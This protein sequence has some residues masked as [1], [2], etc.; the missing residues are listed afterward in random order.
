MFKS[1][2]VS[3]YRYTEEYATNSIVSICAELAKLSVQVVL[4]TKKDYRKLQP[5]LKIVELTES[6]QNIVLFSK[7][8]NMHFQRM[9]QTMLI[10][11]EEEQ[12][13]LTL[14][15]VFFRP[16]YIGTGIENTQNYIDEMYRLQK[17]FVFSN[18]KSVLDI[19]VGRFNSVN[20]ITRMTNL[21]IAEEYVQYLKCLHND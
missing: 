12:N 20:Q 14:K 21:E 8:P 5:Y 19:Y 15:N 4:D 6:L 3:P 13:F 9:L 1:S 17:T 7:D 18:I 2:I 10:P 11:W 16:A